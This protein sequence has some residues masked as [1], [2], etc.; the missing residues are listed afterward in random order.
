MYFK[1]KF[2]FSLIQNL[3]LTG[4]STIVDS[5]NYSGEDSRDNEYSHPEERNH[6]EGYAYV[7]TQERS[8]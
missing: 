5:I 7:V 3:A 1:L 6:G 8:D 4:F 2:R